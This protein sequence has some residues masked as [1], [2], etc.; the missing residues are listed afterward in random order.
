MKEIY[1]SQ[2]SKVD[3]IFTNAIKWLEIQRNNANKNL[4]D[5]FL[6]NMKIFSQIEENINDNQKESE[7]I[8]AE[9]NYEAEK[10]PQ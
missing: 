2:K 10:E 4:S 3:S 9:V 8:K 1:A 7:K 6:Q 5:Q